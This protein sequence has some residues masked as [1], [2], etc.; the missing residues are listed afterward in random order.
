VVLAA[1]FTGY[2]DKREKSVNYLY[3]ADF[4]EWVLAADFTITADIQENAVN[5]LY[6]R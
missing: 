3:I 4:K 5:Y 2:A 1:D 6:D